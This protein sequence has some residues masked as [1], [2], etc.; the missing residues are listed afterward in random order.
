MAITRSSKTF[1]ELTG[2]RINEQ[3]FGRMFNVLVD[4]DRY[5][6]FMNIFRSYMF[7]SD[8]QED[9]SYYDTYE[10]GQE[11]WWDNISVKFYGTPYLW[12]IIPTFNN[13]V[14]PFEG[15]EAGTNLKILKDSY[16]YILLRDLDTIAGM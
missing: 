4:H 7:N 13:I 5:T 1:R 14:N 9:V 15:L 2:H 11:E 3:S 6:R 8:T 12:W 10:V 16:I